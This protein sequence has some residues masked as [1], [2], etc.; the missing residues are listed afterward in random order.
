MVKK[1]EIKLI[2]WNINGIRAAI[3]KDFFKSFKKMDADIFAIQETKIQNEQL[4]DEM[5][6]ISGYEVFWSQAIVKKGYSGVCTYTRIKPKSINYG[7]DMPE[8]DN[9]A[10]IELT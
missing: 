4:T 5:K 3:K 8:F 6:N 7:I 10:M 2:S 9:L 1:K